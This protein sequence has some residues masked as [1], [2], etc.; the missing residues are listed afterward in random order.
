VKGGFASGVGTFFADDTLN[1]QPICVRFRWTQTHT[2]SP[3]WE[4]AFS[5]DA[6]KT[7]EVNWTMAFT[8]DAQSS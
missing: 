1:G 3:S 5:P 8:C 7:W 4:Q 6:G 2:A